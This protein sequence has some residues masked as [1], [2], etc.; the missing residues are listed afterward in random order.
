MLIGIRPKKL[1]L[2]VG[3]PDWVIVEDGAINIAFIR[4]CV[5]VRP[6]IGWCG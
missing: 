3:D 5:P 6:E 1:A 4:T 2:V